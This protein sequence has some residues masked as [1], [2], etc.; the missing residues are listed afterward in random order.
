MNYCL[1]CR[2]FA[3]AGVSTYDDAQLPAQGDRMI[4]K[5]SDN[6]D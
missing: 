3:A 6:V 2:T 1:K 5:I 4:C